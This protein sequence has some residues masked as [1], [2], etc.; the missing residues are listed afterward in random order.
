MANSFTHLHVHTEFSMLDGAARVGERRGR[1]AADGQPALGITDHGN[2]YGVLDFYKACRKQ[3][4][5]PII[6]TELYMAH[7]QPHRA[8][9]A[10]GPHRRLRRRRRGRAQGLLPPDRAGR[11]RRRLQEPHPALQPGVPRGLL[12]QAQGRLG[13]PRAST[14]RASSP[15]PAASAAT[16]CRRCCDGDFDGALAKAARLQDIFGR[17]NL[18]VELQDHGIPE[19]HRT[20]P[21]LLE[22]A[23]QDPGAA[24]RHQRQPL[25]PPRRR[26]W[27]TT[28]CCACRP[29]SLMS[30][31][32]RFKFSGDEHYLKT[33]DEMRRLFGE[34]PEACD[35]T[36]WIA[37]RAN[38]EIEFGKPQLPDF[39][40][41]EGFADDADYLEHLTFEGARE[42]WGDH[43]AR[44][45][46]RAP[47]LR[48]RGHRRHGV[49]VVLP[50]RLGPHQARPRHRHPGRS[51]PWERGR[52]RGGLLPAHHRPRPD[53]V[54][55]A[56]RALPQPVAASRCPTSTW[57]S[58]P[59]TGTR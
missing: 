12:L 38:V 13:A 32:D 23:T 31:P 49:L 3:G 18:F 4:V 10:P 6:G 34:V 17:D 52:L 39:P 29:A 24:A 54:R 9:A 27:P 7:D 16:C 43:A 47:R 22:I 42:R 40:L 30:D 46:R 36:L 14:A 20:N 1:A 41:P 53:Q 55:P 2:M 45:G 11:E 57:T 28:R 25:H 33:A 21:Q 8:P 19:Q 5:K 51:R 48:A 26:T 50:H 56:V 44:R 15:P 59:A 37:E 35:N 58:T